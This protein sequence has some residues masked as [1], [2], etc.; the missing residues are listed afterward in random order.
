MAEAPMIEI[1]LL[2]VAQDAGVPQAGCACATCLAAH[3]DPTLRQYAV[4]LGIIDHTTHQRWMIDATP[5]IRFQLHPLGSPLSGIFLSHAHLG[6]YTGL[7]HLGYEGWH[8]RDIPVYASAQ[9]S[10]FLSRN[11]PFSALLQRRNIQCFPFS[12]GV[13][14]QLSPDLSITPIAV[15]HR[16]EYTDTYAF[17]IQGPNRTLFYCS[18]I[19]YLQSDTFDI[20]PHLV[21]ADIV[22]L[23]ATFYSPA[24]LP[25]RN[26]TD[27][28][29]AYVVDTLALLSPPPHTA[30]FIHLNH[31]NP[32]WQPGAERTLVEQSGWQVG[33]F[34]QR[35]YL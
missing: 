2:G 11:E 6:H 33:T 35:W 28:P 32:L 17:L 29:H 24:D 7:L 22:L 18:D 16:A 30:V 12:N 10:D 20:R 34:L 9:M 15:P 21:S 4:A 19:D 31:S 5:D 8:S 13:T 1:V 27:I 26:L 25:G 3:H 14:L 23:D